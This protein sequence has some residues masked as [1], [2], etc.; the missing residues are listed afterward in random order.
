[1]PKLT[2]EQ[3]QRSSEFRVQHFRVKYVKYVFFTFRHERL[4][5][6]AL[7]LKVGVGLFPN[8]TN[9]LLFKPGAPK[10]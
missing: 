10:C 4:S 3:G 7:R 5:G 9:I 2:D 6:E 8:D 1:M